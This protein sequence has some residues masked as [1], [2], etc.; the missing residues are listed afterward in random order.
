M[1]IY[2]AI[3]QAIKDKLAANSGADSR[4]PYMRSIKTYGGEFDE[5][6][7]AVVRQMP[8]VWVAFAGAGQPK[9]INT[10]GS[11][12][13]VP[14]NYAVM[15]GQ[16]N[17]RDEESTRHGVIVNG[18]LL[19]VGT[20]QMLS[21]VQAL[22]LGEDFEDKGL[23][24]DPLRPG[25]VQTLFNTVYESKA[26]SVFAQ[27]WTTEFVMTKEDLESKNA[28]WLLKIGLDYVMCP[29]DE[30]PDMHDLVELDGDQ[31]AIA[32]GRHT[33]SGQGEAG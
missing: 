24:I 13:L 21:D 14:L 11:K 25:R 31:G 4:M 1:S 32:D 16:R 19:E 17:V 26:L 22:L 33:A 27:T 18:S 10:A 12:W 5:G 30:T 15:V 23:K 6:L 2:A 9:P 7:A 8:A 3:E 29:G 28:P 20:Y